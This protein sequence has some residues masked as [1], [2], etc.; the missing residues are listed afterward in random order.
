MTTLIPLNIAKM[1][2]LHNAREKVDELECV[3]PKFY[4]GTYKDKENGGEIIILK[5]TKCYIT[6]QYSKYDKR[7]YKLKIRN[8][9]WGDNEEYVEIPRFATPTGKQKIIHARDLLYITD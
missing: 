2:E 3:K 4:I 1:E 9:D 8:Y 7:E 5:K 6:F